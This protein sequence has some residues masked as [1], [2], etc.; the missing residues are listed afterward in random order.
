MRCTEERRGAR[1]ISVREHS[2][3]HFG[4]SD[5][6]REIRWSTPKGP[7]NELQWRRAADALSDGLGIKIRVSAQEGEP[8]L[9]LDSVEV[10]TWW[11]RNGDKI[12]GWECTQ[13]DGCRMTDHLDQHGHH[14]PTGLGIIIRTPEARRV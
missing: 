4:W 7:Q 14:V 6:E 13:D 5:D 10:A 12:M 1:C 3:D 9:F 11:E 8:V 2:G